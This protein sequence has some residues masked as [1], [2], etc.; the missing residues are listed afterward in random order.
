MLSIFPMGR[1]ARPWMQVE[2]KVLYIVCNDEPTRLVT[3]AMVTS[4][5]TFTGGNESHHNA[6][7]IP[8]RFLFLSFNNSLPNQQQMVVRRT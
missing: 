1:F 2:W 4:Y 8:F 3:F 6:T 7:S 5:T